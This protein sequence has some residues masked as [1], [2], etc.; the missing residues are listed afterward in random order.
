MITFAGFLIGNMKRY[1]YITIAA[2]IAILCLQ[3]IYIMRLYSQYAN[4]CTVGLTHSLTLMMD[5]EY[6]L[7][8]EVSVATSR[9]RR[10]T[11]NTIALDE[12][13]VDTFRMDIDGARRRLGGVTTGVALQQLREDFVMQRGLMLQLATLDSLYNDTIKGAFPYRLILYDANRQ[14]TDSAGS[15]QGRTADYTSTL[16]PLGTQGKMF[17]QLKAD[18]PVAGFIVRRVWAL[19][20]SAIFLLIV[21]AALFYHLTAI[22]KKSNLL[23]K[24]EERVNGTIHDLKSP[25]NSAITLMS[26]LSMQEVDER[27]HNAIEL[28]MGGLKHLVA[29]IESLLL[30]ARRDRKRLVLHKTEIELPAI[31]GLLKQELDVLY[32]DKPHH[33]EIENELPPQ[34]PVFADAMYI[35]NVLRNLMENALKYADD[36]VAVTVTIRAI[37][38]RLQ[39]QVRD[40]GWGIAPRYQKKV[41]RLFYQVPRNKE[42]SGKGHGIGLT[43]AQYII[44]AHGGKITVESAEGRGSLFTFTIPLK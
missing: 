30:V 12:T 40:N 2:S 26:L 19:L 16:F 34:T 37:D 13:E 22:R 44:E 29:T 33:I 9:A 42:H 15:L 38:N 32:R 1:Y 6:A 18:I 21:L 11:G 36:H 31:A 3:A 41:F 43:Q 4:E 10:A 25:L 35:E 28:C 39:V 17:L 8:N 14:P 20:L 23:S 24:Q 27:K 5:K 7:R